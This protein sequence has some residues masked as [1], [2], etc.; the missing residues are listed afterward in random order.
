MKLWK[1]FIIGLLLL[2]IAFG[3][4]IYLSIISPSF[5]E[6]PEVQVPTDE[7]LSN[8]TQVEEGHIEYLITEIGGYK[9]HD[10]PFTG[11]PAVIEINV[12][13]TGQLYSVTIIDNE[14]H[15]QVGRATNPDLRLHTPLSELVD[16]LGETD[17][18][19]QLVVDK[20]MEGTL[21][22]EVLADEK[23][24][25]VKGYKGVYDTLNKEADIPLTG[26]AIC[27]LDASL[28]DVIKSRQ[29]P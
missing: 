4:Y 14:P 25:A 5:V 10:D 15:V 29:K 28:W 1:W 17:D 24:L 3:V 9:L 6:K 18:F 2:I 26:N 21:W 22:V 7:E 27:T 20:A 16:L 8:V 19:E 12:T 23:T 11:E 13:D